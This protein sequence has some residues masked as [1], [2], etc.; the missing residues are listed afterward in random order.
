MAKIFPL[1]KQVAELIA[2]GEVVERPASAIKEL[3]ENSMDAGATA[4]TVEIRGGGIRYIR[5]QD[6]GYGILQEDVATA[7]LR[8]ATSKV[9]TAED[10]VHIQTLGFRGEALASIAAVSKVEM[11]TRSK[12][13]EMGT[14]LKMAGGEILEK[15]DFAAAVGTSITIRDL[16]FNTPARMKFLKKDQAEANAVSAVMDRLA[17]S[18]PDVSFKYIRD[19]KNTLFT[20]GNGDL[21]ATI[22]A[23]FGKDFAEGLLPVKNQVGEVSVNGFISK[24]EYSRG[25]RSMQYF[26]VNGRFVK[27]VTGQ[28]ALEE[29]YKNEVMVHRYPAGVLFITLPAQLVD[30]NTHPAKI[31]VR[32]VEERK[33]YET[34][35]Y[36]TKNTLAEQ[37]APPILKLSVNPEKTLQKNEAMKYE[38]EQIKLPEWENQPRSKETS[39]ILPKKK[40]NFWE[41]TKASVFREQFPLEKKTN[42]F[43]QSPTSTYDR[44]KFTTLMNESPQRAPAETANNNEPA[45]NKSAESPVPH[46]EESPKTGRAIYEGAQYIG[47]IFRTYVLFAQEDTLYLM[48][49]HA[50]H[51]RLLFEKL[52]TQ[53]VNHTQFLLEPILLT[54]PKEEYQMLLDQKEI[55]SE[56]GIVIDDFGSGTIKIDAFPTMLSQNDISVLMEEIAEKIKKGQKEIMPDVW[57]NLYHSMACKAAI[58]GNQQNSPEE[59]QELL[60]LLWE[61]GEIQHCPHGRPV[62]V[63]L[64]KKELEKRFGRIQ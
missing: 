44:T 52:K 21:L 40:E 12:E 10:L 43:Q 37:G 51:E 46:M 8:N 3:V 28:S 26:F 2:A 7:F 36:A 59:L 22:Y 27:T 63:A 1:E 20:P 42:S 34:I 54:L 25:S 9:R 33:V 45:Y 14:L 48:D 38:S 61:N 18:H 19:G 30:V 32:F 58:K 29:A 23:V 62:A 15:E 47:E 60:R 57:D 41:S 11:R 56:K 53:K 4:I 16:F 35:Y 17:L 39:A 50:A 13:E 5:V 55:L 31:E 49:K 64:T 6:N 24:P